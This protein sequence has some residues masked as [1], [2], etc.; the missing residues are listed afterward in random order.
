I[1]T[2]GTITIDDQEI[3]EI[4]ESSWRENIAI[5]NQEIF[6]F[7]DTIMNNLKIV[8]NQITDEE[9]IKICQLTKADKFIQKLE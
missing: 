1:P 5:I 7:E 2:E 3:R 8:N 9:I 6:L 4:N